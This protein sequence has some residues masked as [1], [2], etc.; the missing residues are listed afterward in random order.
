MLLLVYI[1]LAFSIMLRP[2]IKIES[3]QAD[4]ILQSLLAY[5][6]VVVLLIN[7]LELYLNWAKPAPWPEKYKMILLSVFVLIMA[8][9]GNYLT[10]FP[11]YFNY[12]K[13]INEVNAPTEY[14]RAVFAIRM[15]LAIALL[16]VCVLSFFHLFQN[17]QY[18]SNWQR[19][20]LFPIIVLCCLLFYGVAYYKA[21]KKTN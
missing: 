7:I 17:I 4:K 3:S 13:E 1:K 18:L 5:L 8:F 12:R 16:V 2:N 21:L 9:G 6:A 10:R 15:V 20:Y 11:Q 19:F 14:R